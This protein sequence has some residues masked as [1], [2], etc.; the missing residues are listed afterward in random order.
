MLS[1]GMPHYVMRKLTDEFNF[2]LL[3]PGPFVSF[4]LTSGLSG[5]CI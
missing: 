3:S 5:S 4:T 1:N 2:S